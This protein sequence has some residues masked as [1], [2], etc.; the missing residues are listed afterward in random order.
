MCSLA[1]LLCGVG[2]ILGVIFGF[3]GRSQIRRSGGT[4]TGGG[5]ATAGIIIGFI[6]IALA[7]AWVVLVVVLGV[8]TSSSGS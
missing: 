2:A 8:T 5:L 7:I 1:G 3:V 6:I 4:Q